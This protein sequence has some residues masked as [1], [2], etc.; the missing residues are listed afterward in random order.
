MSV[1]R[2][3]AKAYLMAGLSV[4]P[5]NKA[6]K[7]PC[8][9]QWNEFQTRLPTTDEVQH[10]FVQAQEAICIVC[11]RISGNLEVI[12]FDNHGELFPKWKES[13]P[14]DLLT[15]LVIE[16][17]PSG[18]Y[19]AAYRMESEP[20][21]NI[22]L[23]QGERAGKLQTLI[24]TRGQGGVVL[25][26]PTE[27]YKLQQGDYNELPVLTKDER[28]ILL[29]AA[30]KMNEK[31]E[32]GMPKP[33]RCPDEHFENHPGDDF[34]ARGDVRAV[35]QKHG[36]MSLGIQPDGNEY[37]RRPGKTGG[38]NSATLK[39]GVFY[40]FSSN[41]DPFESNR[42]YNAF[43]AYTLL[44]HNGD[45]GEAATELLKQGYGKAADDN[46]GVD[47][48]ALLGEQAKKDEPPSLQ[49]LTARELLRQY[50]N[51]KEPLIDGL[52][53]REEIM[54]IVAAPK[55]G[56]SWLVMQLTLAL[57]TGGTWCGHECTASRVLL[58]DN[59][60]HRETLSCRLHRVASA[61]GISDD[62]EVLDR[63]T[64]LSQR[65]AE[66]DIRLLKKTCRKTAT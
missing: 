37:W 5:A 13:I 11:G 50:R 41:A 26:A 58:V 29:N 14:A 8:L 65:G 21:G 23:A 15:K 16:Q 43:T 66:K 39:D 18:G 10:W 3:K 53:R 47:L 25:C 32:Q 35:L 56:K 30:W 48:S 57:V 2:E 44:E 4:L 51:M 20:C 33:T 24:E 22:K 36:W 7:R 64:I 61:M 54:N 6:Q 31:P 12:D 40:V 28:E 19:H 9:P 46:C 1:S 34:N 59:E 17:T 42:P 63:L 52:L 49:F 27:G 55:T 45:F 38:G 62:D 60:L